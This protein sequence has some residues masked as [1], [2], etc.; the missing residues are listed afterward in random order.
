M[1]ELAEREGMVVTEDTGGELLCRDCEFYAGEPGTT[2]GTCTNTEAEHYQ[3]IISVHH[4][5]P[6]AD[7]V[8]EETGAVIDGLVFTCFT[9]SEWGENMGDEQMGGNC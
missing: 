7:V 6:E 4:P 2:K 5:A 9:E 3:H 1:A 8:D